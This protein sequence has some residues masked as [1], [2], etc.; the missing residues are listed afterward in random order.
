MQDAPAHVNLVMGHDRRRFFLG[1]LVVS[2]DSRAVAGFRRSG[3]L[4]R[5][6][7]T[8]LL[9]GRRGA[10][11]TQ[12][13]SRHNASCTEIVINLLLAPLVGHPRSRLGLEASRRR[14]A[15]S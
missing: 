12:Q 6:V 4:D 14:S 1:S 2:L 10:Q 9:L 8:F 3:L 11:Q 15:P 5:L 13:T 7:L